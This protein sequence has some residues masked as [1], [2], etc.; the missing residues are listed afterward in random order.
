MSAR[1][2]D[3]RAQAALL[4]LRFHAVGVP[5]LNAERDVIDSRAA[6][7]GRTLPFAPA[8]RAE[9]GIE[10]IPAA[11]DDVADVPDE[12]FVLAAFVVGRCPAKEIRVEGDALLVVRHREG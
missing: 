6:A 10:R 3:L 2:V 1:R 8:A 5:R 4:E 9:I 7:A 12:A 11:D